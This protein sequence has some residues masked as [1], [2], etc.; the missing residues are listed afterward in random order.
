VNYRARSLSTA[1]AEKIYKKKKESPGAVSPAPSLLLVKPGTLNTH[2]EP[3]TRPA[4]FDVKLSE[5]KYTIIDGSHRYLSTKMLVDRDFGGD[6]DKLRDSK[7]YHQYYY[8]PCQILV[9]VTPETARMVSVVFKLIR[10]TML[11]LSCN[12]FLQ[13]IYSAHY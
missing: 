12:R 5:V 6:W 11:S 10:L 1:D 2:N 7:L 4:E 3:I 13:E 8:T 9:G